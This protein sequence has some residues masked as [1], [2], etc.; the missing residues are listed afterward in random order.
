MINMLFPLI[1]YTY[2]IRILNSEIYGL[3]V[4]SQTAC[5]YFIVLINYGFNIS[6]TQAVALNKTNKIKLSEIISS[7]LIIKIILLFFSFLIMSFLI[8]TV[9]LF[10]EEATLFLFSMA[11]CVQ[12]TIFPIWY[13]LGIEK[14]KFITIINVVS[15]VI[16]TILIFI[17]VTQKSD[18]LM[19]PVLNGIGALIAGI[20]SLY[21]VFKDRDIIF[22]MQPPKTIYRY[23]KESTYFFISNLS[24]M[25]YTNFGKFILG[26]TGNM[27]E[28]AYY[29]LGEK[30]LGLLKNFTSIIEQSI[31]ARIS[32]SKDIRMFNQIK[33]YTFLIISVL[34]IF[35]IYFAQN[36][37]LIIGGYAML[38]ASISF[39]ILIF[40]AIP[41]VLST[42]WGHVM[43]LAWNRKEDF[44]KIRLISLFS[45]VL[46]VYSTSLF[47]DLNSISLSIIVLLNEILLVG[48]TFQFSK[49]IIHEKS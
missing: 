22:A 19:V 38:A 32:I 25:I 41:N 10:E 17:F 35:I 39:S 46:L 11:L 23:Y 6:A 36:I 33:N 1:T 34:S 49:K 14:M 4:F 12:E 20:Y 26:I 48:L 18:Y 30:I 21:I 3:I 15:R 37:I 43:L 24:G 40:V 8:I 45:F 5:Q 42:F 44:L 9:P 28:V 13:F 2:L 27:S 31:F 47:T 29:D 7:I 16:F